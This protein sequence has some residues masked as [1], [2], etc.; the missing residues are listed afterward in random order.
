MISL[1]ELWD[2]TPSGTRTFQPEQVAGLP[3][4]ARRY[5]THAIA[6]G[7]RLASAVRLRMHGQ[8]KLKRWLPFRAEQVLCGPRGM[9][10]KATVHMAGLP[11][12]GFDRLLNGEGAMQWKL[13]GLVPVMAAS[14]PDI[15]RSAAGRVKAECVWLPSALC[16][17]D[18]SW[19]APQSSR[20]HARFTVPEDTAELELALND[21]GRLMAVKLPRW[22]NPE[23]AAFH[24][25]DFGGAAEEEKTFGGYTIPTR[26]RVGWYFE[27]PRFEADGEFFRVTI[28]EATY[29]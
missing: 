13:C 1:D 6:P 20:P 8:I 14:G 15:T 17:E 11:I 26:L 2:A 12:R 10:W 23:G 29:K 21:T 22:G 9:L 16:G 28:D 7:T 24:T 5:L 27:T 19:T 18:V 25:V 3:E 4:A